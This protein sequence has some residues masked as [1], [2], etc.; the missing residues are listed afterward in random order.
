MLRRDFLMA[1][2]VVAASA[3]ASG[4]SGAGGASTPVRKLIMFNHVSLDGFFTDASGDMSWAHARDEEWQRF[5][6][7][8]AGGDAELV[9][10]RKTYEMMAGFWPTPQAKQALPEVAASMNRM[11]KY[12]FSRTLQKV[13]WEN[14]SLLTGDLAREV[15]NLKTQRGPALLIM[16]SG[17]IVSQ[18]TGAGLIDEYQLVTVPL[19]VGRGRSL[20]EGVTTRPRLKLTRTRTFQN[21]NVVNWYSV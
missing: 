1:T 16:G 10:G 8:N 11:R 17:E 4:G 2:S 13:E 9:F 3:M 15:R 19:I 5:T 18:L 12:V 14:S 6:N 21:G 20:F 7:E